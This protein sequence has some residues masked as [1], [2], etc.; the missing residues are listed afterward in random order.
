MNALG[1]HLIVELYGCRTD[2]LNDAGKLESFMREAAQLCG[3]T[4]L[5]TAF[6]KFNPHG[7]SGVV[8]IAESH[9]TI[10]TWPEYGYASV[11][12]FTCGEVL[13][14]ED[15]VNYLQKKLDAKSSTMIEMKRGILHKLRNE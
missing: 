9:L 11:D 13:S 1:R 4:I 10:H 5:K 3:A 8:V 12:V 15:A 2:V 7:I 14:P 6:H